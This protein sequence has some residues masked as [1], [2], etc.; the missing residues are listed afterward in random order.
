MD[1]WDQPESLLADANR[2]MFREPLLSCRLLFGQDLDSRWLFRSQEKK[3][4]SSGGFTDHLLVRLCGHPGSISKL[5]DDDAFYE[6]AFYDNVID[7]PHFGPRLE[8][9]QKYVGARKPR[10]VKDLWHDRRDPGQW[11]L[12]WIVLI[13]TV[14]T[15][16]LS[17]VQIGLGACQVRLAQ[18]QVRLAEVALKK[19]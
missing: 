11:V 18:V 1:I 14:V 17:L 7:F 10:N 9:L 5:T 15:I 2:S 12:I 6:Q 16:L 13:L 3:R 8:I 19:E 4:A